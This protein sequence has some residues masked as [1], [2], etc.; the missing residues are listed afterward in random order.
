MGSESDKKVRVRAYHLW[1]AEGCP[2]GRDGEFWERAL[3]LEEQAN[4]LGRASKP[5]KAKHASTAQ[6]LPAKQAKAP[7]A[8]PPPTGKKA[9]KR[10]SRPGE[11]EDASGTASMHMR[12]TPAGQS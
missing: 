4:T 6:P 8:S 10:R 1:E 9:L 2:K 11:A 3:Q 12:P 5:P 7:K